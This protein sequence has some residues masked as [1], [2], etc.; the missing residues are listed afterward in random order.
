MALFDQGTAPAVL[1]NGPN[2][3]F[4]FKLRQLETNDKAVQQI[5]IEQGAVCL[6]ADADDDVQP[7]KKEGSKEPAGYA[8]LS[9]RDCAYKVMSLYGVDVDINKTRTE[10]MADIAGII[11]EYNA[12]HEGEEAPPAEP[13]AEVEGATPDEQPPAE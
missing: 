11:E 10:M 5:L 4:E 12:Q 3:V 7:V 9:K 2:I 6:Q 13:E 8:G 1:F